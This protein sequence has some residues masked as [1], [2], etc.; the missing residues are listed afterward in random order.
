MAPRKDSYDFHDQIGHLLRRAY[1]RH[2]AIFQEAIPD[3]DLTAAQFVALCAVK[4]QQPCS[5]NDIVKATAIDQ[6]TIRGVVERL[7]ARA[8]IEVGADP[9]DGRKLVVR[10]TAAGLALIERTVP[11]AQE[12]TE[13]T[14]GALN[15]GERV[16][17]LFLLRK[18]MESDA[19]A[20]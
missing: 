16:A 13:R 1:Q 11:F 8:L 3:S 2:V 15:A 4:E 5:L 14:Y 10:P 12:V 7:K 18:M 9:N 6:A 19:D 17:M 20:E